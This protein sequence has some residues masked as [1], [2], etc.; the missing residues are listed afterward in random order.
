MGFK[1]IQRFV[2]CMLLQLL[3]LSSVK[4]Q[5][6]FPNATAGVTLF[7]PGQNGQGVSVTYDPLNRIYYSVSGGNTL[8]NIVTYAE[9]G[10][11][12]G[13]DTHTQIDHRGLWWDHHGRK[14]MTNGFDSTG[15]YSM[16]IDGNNIATDSTAYFSPSFQPSSQSVAAYD[17]INDKLLY[18]FGGDIFVCDLDQ[19][20]IVSQITVKN[21][22]RPLYYYSAHSLAFTGIPGQEVVLFDIIHNEAS[23]I[24]LADGNFQSAC[25]LPSTSPRRPWQD[26]SYSNGQIFIRDGNSWL[27]YKVTAGCHELLPDSIADTL[28]ITCGEKINLPE[29]LS[30]CYGKIYATTTSNLVYTASGY[31]PIDW[32]FTDPFGNSKIVRQI[33]SVT[34]P[35]FTILPTD[36]GLKAGPSLATNYNW[37][38]CVPDGNQ[39]LQEH[40]PVFLPSETGNYAVITN[41][42]G[43]IDTS[44]CLYF[45]RKEFNNGSAYPLSV[46]PNPGDGYFTLNQLAYHQYLVTDASGR[47]LF[48]I[49]ATHLDYFTVDLRNYP[50]GIYFIRSAGGEQQARLVVVR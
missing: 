2:Y 36:Q 20:Q 26:Y 11:Q 47:F 13:V 30:P 24:N 5:T 29:A 23:F 10:Q 21:L 34:V 28:Q 32:E 31:Y 8:S 43:C 46:T 12:I 19:Q 1:E 14:L 17:W 3:L 15:I 18:F 38:K 16:Y 49:D 33:V 22:P 25:I 40:E 35:E 41:T 50:T 6:V 4:G 44:E 7:G 48:N 9:T 45:S 39:L 42:L 27:G 37:I